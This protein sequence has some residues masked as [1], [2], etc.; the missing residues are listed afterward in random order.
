MINSRNITDL[1][2]KVQELCVDFM[3]KCKQ[4]GIDVL[5]TSTY[6]DA[7]S[8]QALYSQGR[9]VPGKRVTNAQA[10]E[11]MHNW[12]CAFDFV[13][14]VNGKAMWNSTD[15]FTRCGEI[16]ESVGLEWAGRWTRFK[17]MAHCQYT[18]GLTLKDFQNGKTL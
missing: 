4:E 6:R 12:K 3:A 8:Q 1:H 18:N 7:A 2:P 16:A 13:P 9:T 10:G 17:E 5:I 11:S 14:I 15:L